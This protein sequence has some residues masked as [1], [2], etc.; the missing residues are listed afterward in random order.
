MVLMS[1]SANTCINE[2][3]RPKLASEVRIRAAPTKTQWLWVDTL[4]NPSRSVLSTT[5]TASAEP[6]S[7][8][9][10]LPASK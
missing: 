8:M 10:A 4:R 7:S 9:T 1:L 6:T 3:K 5:C 2:A